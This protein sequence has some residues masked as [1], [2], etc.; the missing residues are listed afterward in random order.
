MKHYFDF[1]QLSFHT[2]VALG[3]SE[4]GEIEI[5]ASFVFPKMKNYQQVIFLSDDCSRLIEFFDDE[6]NIYKLNK[7]PF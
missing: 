4:D 7:K 2:F 6:A 1:V 3:L 5:K